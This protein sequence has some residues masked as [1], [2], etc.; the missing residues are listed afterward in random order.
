MAFEEKYEK[1]GLDYYMSVIARKITNAMLSYPEFMFLGKILIG[2]VAVTILF[3]IF[4]NMFG[5]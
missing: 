1:A 3:L 5:V 2:F 4:K